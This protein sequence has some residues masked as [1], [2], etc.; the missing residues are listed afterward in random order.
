M[1]AARPTLPATG[2]RRF[3]ATL[4]MRTSGDAKVVACAR[5]DHPL[6][7]A[8]SSWKQHAQLI[9][10]PLSTLDPVYTTADDVV[11][12]QFLCPGCGALLDTET[13]ARGD[14][15]LEDRVEV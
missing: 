12:R 15:F 10:V 9:E 14:P 3:S 1:N 8:G 13:A 7:D 5:C 4:L 6:A 11:A 2:I